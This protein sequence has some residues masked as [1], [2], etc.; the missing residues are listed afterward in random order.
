M[1]YVSIGLGVCLVALLLA[2]SKPTISVTDSS[3]GPPA[4]AADKPLAGPK[5]VA[6]TWKEFKQDKYGFSVLLPATPAVSEGVRPNE[7]D[8]DLPIP[9]TQELGERTGYWISVSE[10]K[11]ADKPGGEEIV[12]STAMTLGESHFDG[13]KSVNKKSGTFAGKPG[14]AWDVETKKVGTI[15]FRACLAGIKLYILGAGPDAKVPAAD[16][17]KF[18]SSFEVTGK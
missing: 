2:C 4:V 17:E 18:F 7:A 5:P 15:H 1:R 3:T 14:R 11:G 12:F 10:F 9:A 13:A 6:G 16:A 8:F